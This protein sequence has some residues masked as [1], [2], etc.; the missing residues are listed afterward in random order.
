MNSDMLRA[1]QALCL[2][3]VCTGVLWLAP[4][5]SALGPAQGAAQSA[6]DEAAYKDLVEQALNEFKHRNWPEARVLFMRAHELNPNARTLRGMGIVSFEMRDY[7]NAATNLKA[8]LDDRRQPLTDAQRKECEALLT[9]A[10]TFVGVYTLKL[11]PGDAHVLLDG[12]EVTRDEEGHLLVPFGDHTLSARAPGRQETSTRLNVQGGERGEIALSLPADVPAPAVVAGAA[13]APVAAQAAPPPVAP[14]A[15][16]PAPKDSERGFVGH[17]LKYTWV[18]LGAS[19]AFGATAVALWYVGDNKLSSLDD[20]CRDSANAGEGCAKGETDTKEIELYQT[21][22]NVSIGV[23]AAALV[24]A[25]IL[26]GLEWPRE[27][28]LAIGVGDRSFVLRGAF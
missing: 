15:A 2:A 20:E 5:P 16:S 3:L 12:N 14:P 26:M 21:L 4:S 19:A 13:V 27:R 22:T 10:R 11:D 8:A 28:R 18:A 24:T 7:L 9:R 23:S 6:R 17:G 25:G 1:L